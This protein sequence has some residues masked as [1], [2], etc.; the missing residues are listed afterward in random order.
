MEVNLEDNSTPLQASSNAAG[1]KKG[2]S[3]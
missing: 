1:G 2:V 3:A